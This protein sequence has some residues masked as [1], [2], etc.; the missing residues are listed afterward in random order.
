MSEYFIPK[1]THKIHILYTWNILYTQSPGWLWGL[2]AG[3]YNFSL[4]RHFHLLPVTW[5]LRVGFRGN[6]R[7]LGLGLG[8]WQSWKS[9]LAQVLARV[10]GLMLVYLINY[11]TYFMARIC[12]EDFEVKG[13][14]DLELKTHRFYTASCGRGIKLPCIFAWFIVYMRRASNILF[15]R[16]NIT[17]WSLI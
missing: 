12:I 1:F 15:R 5:P 8:L 13:E 16:W 4:S 9:G 11:L 14:R 7:R 6:H 17:L 2:V 3:L 10:L